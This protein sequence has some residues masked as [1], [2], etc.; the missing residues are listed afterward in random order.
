MK[1]KSRMRLCSVC[2]I[3]RQLL[4]ASRQEYASF[5]EEYLF[6]SQAGMRF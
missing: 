5:P 4:D 3:P 2:F 6:N 1:G